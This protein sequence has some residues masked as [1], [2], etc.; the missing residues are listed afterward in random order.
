[1]DTRV[2][3]KVKEAFSAYPK[4]LYPKGQI[5]LFADEDPSHIFYI[6]SGKVRMF[7]IT[8]RGDEAITNIFSDGSFFPMSLLL[9]GAPNSY[10]Y[11]TEEDTTIHLVPPEVVRQFLQDNPDVT[12]DIL[13]RVYSGVDGLLG[14]IVHLMTGSARSRLMYELLIEARRFGEKQSDGAIKL[15]VNEQDLAA[16]AGMTRETVSREI[17]RLKTKNWLT[18]GKHGGI[19]ILKLDDIEAALKR[20][21]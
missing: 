7:A 19:V 4:R 13:G 10:Y 15:H 17:Q 18:I 20:V 11:K 8:Y 1:M 9:G 16:R 3:Q 14:R 12:M 6:L 5:L 21:S 2:T